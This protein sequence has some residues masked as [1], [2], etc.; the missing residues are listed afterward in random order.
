MSGLDDRIIATLEKQIRAL[1]VENA[2]LEKDA[3]LKKENDHA[4]AKDTAGIDLEKILAKQVVDKKARQEQAQSVRVVVPDRIMSLIPYWEYPENHGKV[5]LSRCNNEED[6]KT[7]I[8]D[9]AGVDKAKYTMQIHVPLAGSR[10]KSYMSLDEAKV[11]VEHNSSASLG[12]RKVRLVP[13]QTVGS[14]NSVVMRGVTLEH[15]KKFHSKYPGSDSRT[16]QEALMAECPDGSSWVEWAAADSAGA[17]D[18]VI[19]YSWDLH[20]D[21][22]I[23]FIESRIGPNVR[24]WIDILA[25]AQ[26]PIQRGNL[27]EIVQLPEVVNFAG[28]TIVM[29]G[30]VKRLWCNFEFAWSVELNGSSLVYGYAKSEMHKLAPALQEQVTRLVKQDK[31]MLKMPGSRLIEADG[32]D[33]EPDKRRV[34]WEGNELHNETCEIVKESEAMPK[35]RIDKTQSVVAVAANYIK[36]ASRCYS[37]RDENF[38]RA[39][40]ENRLGGKAQVALLIKTVLYDESLLEEDDVDT[41][42][43]PLGRQ[44][45]QS[46]DQ[47]YLLKLFMQQ[48]GANWANRTNWGDDRLEL[49]QWNG[50]ATAKD[51]P[52]SVVKLD[53][54]G[55]GLPGE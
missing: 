37:V 25:C 1:E 34:S 13:S 46:S 15:I 51:D 38:I 8:C 39:T 33:V 3:A 23:M 24:I 47:E 32:T 28:T 30:T 2:A 14:L 35:I 53:L 6:L 49:G 42:G 40:I 20:W 45:A 7:K 19:S 36:R 29:P 10:I 22:L 41:P 52:K 9:V 43:S 26:H 27:D 16:K 54:K 4:S 48:G 18:A 44:S 5:F 11:K 12:G 31:K 17:P 21:Y 55:Q 50:V